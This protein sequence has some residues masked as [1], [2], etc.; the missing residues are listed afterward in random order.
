[1]CTWLV[2]LLLLCFFFFLVVSI[3]FSLSPHL[4]FWGVPLGLRGKGMVSSG[5][6][7]CVVF[8]IHL[9]LRV[10]CVLMHVHV[11]VGVNVSMIMCILVWI[12]VHVCVAPP[13]VVG[14]WPMAGTLWRL[15]EYYYYYPYVYILIKGFRSSS[16]ILLVGL[17][18]VL[19]YRGWLLTWRFMNWESSSEFETLFVL[20]PVSCWVNIYVLEC[21]CLYIHVRICNITTTAGMVIDITCSM[22][23]SP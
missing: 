23:N 3:C 7:S 16:I 2:S 12:H 13:I 4:G 1:M 15:F 9:L 20:F 11:L 18:H 6:V 19:Y 14:A 8:V 21:I 17:L 5:K 10:M 22:L